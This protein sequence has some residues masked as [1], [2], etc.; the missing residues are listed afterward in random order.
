MLNG[1]SLRGLN[2]EKF[3]VSLAE[4]RDRG[5]KMKIVE[6]LESDETLSG[7]TT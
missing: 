1:Y 5:Y 4:L 2:L 3:G 6:L 7:K